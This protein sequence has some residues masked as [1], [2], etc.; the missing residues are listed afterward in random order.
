MA[1]AWIG[2]GWMK[3]SRSRARNSF[4]AS[5]SV[6]KVFDG[7]KMSTPASAAAG[8]CLR[9]KA[10]ALMFACPRDNGRTC[11]DEIPRGYVAENPDEMPITHSRNAAVYRPDMGQCKAYRSAKV[12]DGQSPPGLFSAGR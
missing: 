9:P 6:V 4:S 10:S 8:S 5:P 7:T 1:V 11:C 12:N 3:R 2:V